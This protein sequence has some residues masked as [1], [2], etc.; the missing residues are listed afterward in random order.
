MVRSRIAPATPP[1]TAT[2]LRLDQALPLAGDLVAEPGGARGV[3]GPDADGVGDVGRERRIAQCQQKRERDEASAAGHPVEDA[4]RPT[5]RGRA[6][7]CGTGSMALLPNIPASWAVSV[8]TLPV[9]HDM[10][11]PRAISDLP[12]PHWS[13]A[14][15][16]ACLSPDWPGRARGAAVTVGLL[17]GGEK[18]CVEGGSSVVRLTCLLRRKPGLTPEEFHEH[19]REVHGPLIAAASMR[20]PRAALRAAPATDVGLRRGRRRRVTTG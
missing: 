9:S 5:P 20:E 7:R 12:F 14:G 11:P 10:S 16:V 3:A 4:R 1:T 6:G 13:G 17:F 2:G 19:W 18:R 8:R 15:P